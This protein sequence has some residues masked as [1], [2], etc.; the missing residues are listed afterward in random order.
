MQSLDPNAFRLWLPPAGAVVQVGA[1]RR[2]I[3]LPAVPLPIPRNQADDPSAD[4]IGSG[5]YDYLRR[6]PDCPHNTAYAELLRDAFPHFL[7]DM[8]AQTIMLD[9]KTVDAPFVRRKITCM[10]ILSLLDPDNPGLLQQLGIACYELGLMF[11]E[12]P[13]SRQ[14]LLAAM[15]F[16]QR[17]LK[18]R[19]DDAG[20]LN[21][22]G[23]IEFLLGDFAM[24]A[25]RWRQV[26]SSLV[27]IRRD[28]LQARLQ[29]IEEGEVPDHPLA[30]DLEAIGDALICCGEGD[31][32]Q[33]RLILERLEEEGSVPA[34][35]PSPEFY[36]LL[37]HCRE[38]MGD[39]G[40]AF[41]AFERALALDAG[42]AAALEGMD[43]I[44][45]KRRMDR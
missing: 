4:V 27:G 41:E 7:A 39:P 15:G 25:Q 30:D 24:A 21:L 8:A 33:A 10:K 42:H 17:S 34:E 6:F 31:F 22:L 36:S 13:S 40:G 29:R 23:E 20:I 45:D 19:P 44:L 38:K 3:P 16:L 14:H 32:R 43:R 37:G 12:L 9:K 11:T 2:D 5:L 35:F 26:V 18:G 1:D 28:A